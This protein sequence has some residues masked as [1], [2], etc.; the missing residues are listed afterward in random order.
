[1]RVKM[2]AHAD[3]ILS[4]VDSSYPRD[5]H[6]AVQLDKNLLKTAQNNRVLYAFSKKLSSNHQ[7]LNNRQKFLLNCIIG[8]GDK[9]I[10]KYNNTLELLKRLGEDRFAII[11]TIKYLQDITFDVDI[12]LLNRET[13][14]DCSVLTGASFTPYRIPGGIEFRTND[15]NY[16]PI[17]IYDQFCFNRKVIITRADL[18]KD[19]RCG[20]NNT[21]V[22]C[23]EIELALYVAQINFQN[24]FITLH[25]FIQTTQLIAKHQENINWS[26]LSNLT[27]NRSW[28][29]SF[30][31]TLSIIKSIY[32]SIYES[33]LMIPTIN[34]PIKCTFPYFLNPISVLRADHELIGNSA[35]YGSFLIKELSYFNY[36]FLTYYVRNNLPIYRDWIN[37]NRLLG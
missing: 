9:W 24:R 23:I 20:P 36:E 30:W 14:F 35:F 6:G 17:D 8:E 22:P 29:R 12:I 21:L 11:K 32:E 7:N 4:T 13:E 1:M 10:K 18:T 37:L 34:R 26:Y 33:D 3:V 25:D 16:L 2:D 5:Y 15:T 31:Q 27:E 28:S 19:L